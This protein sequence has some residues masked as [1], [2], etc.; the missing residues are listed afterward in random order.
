MKPTTRCFLL[1]VMIAGCTATNGLPRGNNLKNEIELI[2]WEQLQS[3]TFEVTVDDILEVYTGNCQDAL[4]VELELNGSSLPTNILTPSMYGS[5]ITGILHGSNGNACWANIYVSMLDCSDMLDTSM[6]DFPVNVDIPDADCD[7]LSQNLTPDYMINELGLDSSES[8]VQIDVSGTCLVPAYAYSDQVIV[9][10]TSTKI[11]RTWTVIEW[12]HGTF[13]ENVQVIDLIGTAL[14]VCDTLPWNAPFGDCAS[15]HT[16]LDAV[17]WPADVTI[18]NSAY[19]P[20]QMV[21]ASGINPNDAE[22]Q[23]NPSICETIYV[24]YTDIFVDNTPDPMTIE[25]TWNLFTFGGTLGSY[26]Q[27]ITVDYVPGDVYCAYR[28]NGDAIPDVIMAPG[29]STDDTGCVDLSGYS[30]DIIEPS[31]TGDPADGLDLEDQLIMSKDILYI[32]PIT[33]PFLKNAAEINGN[34]AVTTLD[35]VLHQRIIDGLYTVDPVWSFFDVNAAPSLKN[36][37]LKS[38]NNP[39]NT[40]VG[41]KKGDLNDSY[42]LDNLQGNPIPENDLLSKDQ[43]LNSGQ[44]YRVELYNQTD[45]DILGLNLSFLKDEGIRIK[46]IFAPSLSGFNNENFS[47]TEEGVTINYIS[48]DLNDPISIDKN[49]PIL[50]LMVEAMDNGILSERLHLVDDQKNLLVVAEDNTAKSIKLKWD[51][52]IV[53]KVDDVFDTFTFEVYPNPTANFLFVKE[54]DQNEIISLEVTDMEGRIL[55]ISTSESI[56]VSH[57][58]SG[59]YLIGVEKENGVKSYKTFIKI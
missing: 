20:S 15:G 26:T 18:T 23:V 8:I 27:V 57:L 46:N 45:E 49:I 16:D 25:R 42:D 32:D 24:D 52:P 11:I 12:V 28:K 31:K 10:P 36:I 48:E 40:F 39:F 21:N 6:V 35:I 34:G 37:I 3:E 14:F 1:A 43:V 22:P 51:N 17:E 50:I 33:C 55:N 19:L 4:W 2:N 9:N 44:L 53:N 47:S 56:N 58:D 30:G 38:E 5:T 41:V 13:I 59:I 7:L 29:F 54:I